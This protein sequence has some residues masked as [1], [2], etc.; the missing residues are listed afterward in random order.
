[1]TPASAFFIPWEQMHSISQPGGQAVGIYGVDGVGKSSLAAVIPGAQFIDT[2]HGT[3]H[4]SVPRVPIDSVEALEQFENTAR[5]LARERV[6]VIVID[7]IDGLERFLRQKVADKF[8]VDSIARI[9][10]GNGFI[11]LREAFN[12]FLHLLDNYLA[13][14]IHV[15]VI[16]HAKV[17]RR[18]PPGLREAFDRF[19]IDLDEINSQSLKRWLDALLFYTFD[20]RI[21]ETGDGR[22]IGISSKERQLWTQY[23]PAF[24]AKSRVLMPEKIEVPTVDV[25]HD[26]AKLYELIHPLFCELSP[27]QK[28]V[29]A[30]S[31][32]D[33][34]NLIGYLIKLRC[35]SSGQ[36]IADLT[37]KHA[38]QLLRRMSDF[39]AGFE[40]FCAESAPSPPSS[41]SQ[42]QQPEQ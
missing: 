6:R 29:E 25:V 5:Q 33:S 10:Y 38:Q 42:Q 40:R 30:L 39:R 23:S 18:Q 16:A 41:S 15:V 34:A 17:R 32:L 13:A 7:T 8:R 4:L 9:K 12:Q 36:Q 24:D 1:M 27:Q 11:Y 28:I 31:D 2:E 21:S 35:L 19:E 22:P 20:L 37:T 3:R 14:G 26:G